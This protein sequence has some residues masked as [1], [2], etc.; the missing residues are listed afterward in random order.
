[1]VIGLNPN[2]KVT[3]V[4]TSSLIRTRACGFQLRR[5]LQFKSRKVQ[6]WFLLFDNANAIIA[7]TASSDQNRKTWL[8][9]CRIVR[10]SPP[11]R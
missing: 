10:I 2:Y 7:T 5:R 6:A 1:M 11:T 4:T 8:K 3:R 9:W